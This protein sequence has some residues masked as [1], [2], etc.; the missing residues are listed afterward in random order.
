MNEVLLSNRCFARRGGG[1]LT[2]KL[3]RSV[4]IHTKCDSLMFLVHTIHDIIV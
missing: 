2:L 4:V 3:S 1:P